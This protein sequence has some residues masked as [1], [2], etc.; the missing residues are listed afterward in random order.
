MNASL[1]GL[2][3]R[4]LRRV[5]PTALLAL[6]LLLVALL[7][8]AWVHELD[9]QADIMR[10]NLA[11]KRIA[12]PV[13]ATPVLR[14]MPLS[15]QVDAFVGTFPPLQTSA[16]DLEQVFRSASAHDVQL[17]KGEYKFKQNPNE[18]LASYTAIF[19]VHA[20]Y[21]SIRDFSADVLRALPNASIEDLRMV[22]TSADSTML[23]AVV[24]F[25]FVYRR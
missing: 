6:A 4:L 1:L 5:G 17:P 19:P 8:A 18:P 13:T 15:E 2:W 21:G 12:H 9:Y 25:T 24:R 11:A 10:A 22:R 3:H 16:T 23:E 7:V 20:N 14:Q